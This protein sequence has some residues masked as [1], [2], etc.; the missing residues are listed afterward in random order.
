MNLKKTSSVFLLLLL[1]LSQVVA[2]DSKVREALKNMGIN[3]AEV[4]LN[5]SSI[6]GLYEVSQGVRV[7]YITEDGKYLT[8]GNVIDLTT[9]ENLTQLSQNKIRKE[10]Y[11]QIPLSSMII[12]PAEGKTKRTIAIFTDIDCPYCRKMHLEI[13]ALNT[14]G[15][16]VRYLAYPRSGV[17]RA[18][19][20]KM[21]S[22][23][24]A[25]NPAEAMDQLMLTGK[26][27][28][29]TCKNPVRDHLK[30]VQKFGVNGTPNIITDQGEM[31][32]GYLPAKDLLKELRIN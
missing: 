22:A 5:K 29:Q 10:L 27:A 21:V 25:E 11:D 13:P 14:A 17:G 19:Y 24:C 32:P 9:G 23:W 12:Y 18:S 8:I 28:E 7:F 2:D 31:F 26:I 20:V 30:L 1:P 15:V 6:D 3:I 4:G 16:E